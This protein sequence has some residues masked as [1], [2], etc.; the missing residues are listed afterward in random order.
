MTCYLVKH[1]VSFIFISY[2]GILLGEVDRFSGL[3]FTRLC[4]FH[5]SRVSMLVILLDFLTL[6]KRN[7][8]RL[9][10]KLQPLNSVLRKT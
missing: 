10:A 9:L 3:L 6:P 7:S 5:A 1:R 4:T 8:S 2:G